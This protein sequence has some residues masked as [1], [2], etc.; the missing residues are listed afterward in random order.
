MEILIRMKESS[1]TGPLLW[2]GERKLSPGFTETKLLVPGEPIQ[3]GRHAVLQFSSRTF[4]DTDLT[5]LFAVA[6]QT[7]CPDSP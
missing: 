6:T 2:V 5:M 7:G 3:H 1:W 4:S